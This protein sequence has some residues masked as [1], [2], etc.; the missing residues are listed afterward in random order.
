LTALTAFTI[1]GALNRPIVALPDMEGA[2]P[3]Y[4]FI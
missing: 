2:F 1:F 4:G 3:D